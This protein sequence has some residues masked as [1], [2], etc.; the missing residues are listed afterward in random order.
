ML[1]LKHIHHKKKLAAPR[2]YRHTLLDHLM[3]AIAFAGPIM[4]TPQIYD[5][6]VK[7]TLAVNPVTWGSYLLFGFLWLYYGLVHKEKLIIFSNILG[8]V[9]TGLV[10]LGSLIF[11]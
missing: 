8:I 3:Y 10:F 4:T 6:W 5:I 2:K 9:T 7:R 11:A 1:P